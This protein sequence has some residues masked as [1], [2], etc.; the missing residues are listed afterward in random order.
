MCGAGD[1][2]LMESLLRAVVRLMTAV[3]RF[4]VYLNDFPDDPKEDTSLVQGLF[5]ASG[6][7]QYILSQL[8]PPQRQLL[9][10]V[11]ETL[12]QEEQQT[13][14]RSEVLWFYRRLLD[15]L[16]LPS[17]PGSEE[18]DSPQEQDD[19]PNTTTD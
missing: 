19:R 1:Y 7:A 4:E 16:G 17:L 13:Q 11:V 8:D 15:D 5:D 3:D 2:S 9:S 12:H 10:Q 14:G 6:E 18:D